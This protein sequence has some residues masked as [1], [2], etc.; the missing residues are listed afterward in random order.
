MISDR[1]LI[2]ISLAIS[3]IGL[4]LLFL[5]V[6]F[7]QPAK[8]GAGDITEGMSGNIVNVAGTV[9]KI[10]VNDG[11]IFIDFSDETGNINI[12]MFQKDAVNTDAYSIKD[13]DSVTI[14]GKVTVYKM[15]LEIV[16]SSVSLT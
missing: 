8:I 12:V 7:Y 3:A 5:F 13:G 10:N 1:S 16:A 9:D 2:R 15:R 11:N 14:T 6:Q 4:V